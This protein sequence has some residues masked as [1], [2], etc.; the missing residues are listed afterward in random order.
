ML[1]CASAYGVP[2]L[3]KPDFFIV[4]AAKSGTTS[5]YNYLTQHPRVFMPANKEP[6]FFG[7]W[8]GARPRINLEEYLKLFEGVPESIAAGEASTTY[9][10]LQSAA[11]E[12]KAF[13]PQAKI[14]IILRNPVDRA[15]SQYWHNFR[16]GYVSSSFEEELKA[17]KR[18]LSEGWEGFFSGAFA[19]AYYIESG[20]YAEQIDRFL[21]VFGEDSVRVYLFE[22]LV[23]SAQGVC[24]DVF[25]FLE[26]N[27]DFPVNIERVY[28]VSGPSR[29][30][31]LSTLLTRRLRSKELVKKIVP[32]PWMRPLKEWMLRKNTKAVPPM[33]PE[34]RLKLQ[35]V[36]R[37]DI[38][39]AQELLGRDLSHWLREA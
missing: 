34:T 4:G 37:E 7:E 21:K 22:D 15:Y 23:R 39:Y 26:V 6:Y 28:N 35:Q 18:R 14:I 27:P 2:R 3:R 5:L 38:L 12:I 31:A 13:Q 30:A 1:G 8:R 17:E 32:T 20:R 36:F 25:S 16:N 9:L 10:Y 24:Y 33:N 29:S 11:D 19:P